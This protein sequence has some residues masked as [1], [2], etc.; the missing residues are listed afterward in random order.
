VLVSRS[1]RKVYFA[2]SGGLVF[3]STPALDCDDI[4][5]RK[6]PVEALAALDQAIAKDPRDAKALLNR[7]ALRTSQRDAKGALSDLNAVIQIDPH[8]PLALAARADARGALGDYEGAFADSDA[9]IANG[10]R[11]PRMYVSRAM[12][13]RARGDTSGAIDEFG[14]ALKLDP[15]HQGALRGR[16][17]LLFHAGRFEAAENDFASLL[18]IRAN[19]IDSIWLSMART[20]RG[21]E[22][23]AVLEKALAALK[24]AAWPAP[25][26]QYLLGRIDR[27]ALLAAAAADEERRKGRVCEARFYAAEHLIAGGGAQEAR[28]LLEAARDDCPRNFIEYDAA[29]AELA[30]PG[31]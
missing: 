8:N 30:K 1:Q 26:V 5:F 22:G 17:F 23:G 31:T 9:A 13:R 18:A 19:A 12:L 25:V 16:G 7:G 11:I 2:Y 3:P 28:P 21:L 27:E 4:L 14:E 20:R 10:M 24:D 15:R 29:V 6:G